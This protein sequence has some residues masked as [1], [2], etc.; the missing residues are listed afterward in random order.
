MTPPPSGPR[1]FDRSL[2]YACAGLARAWSSQPH[3]R[4]EVV[5][6]IVAVGA[7]VALG[8]GVAVVVA[9]S[10]LVLTAELANTAVEAVV[11]RLLP[12]PDPAAAIAKDTAAAAVLVASLGAVGVGLAVFGPPLWAWLATTLLRSTA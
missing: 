8:D 2:G 10:A 7:A 6:A 3:L 5:A 9:V 11:D 12:E 1:R 4:F